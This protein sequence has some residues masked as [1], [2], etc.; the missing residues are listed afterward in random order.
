MNRCKNNGFVAITSL[1]IIAAVV[2]SVTVSISL[3]GVGELQNTQTYRQGI[4]TK[5]L[6]NACMEEGLQRL[7]NNANYSGGT[8]QLPAGSCTIEVTPVAANYSINITA[9]LDGPPV[10]RQRQQ[11]EVKRV[12]RSINIIDWQEQ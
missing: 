9:Q 5:A 10:Y 1:L 2:L 12:G 4:K 11:L 3:L 7:K 8:L 6:A